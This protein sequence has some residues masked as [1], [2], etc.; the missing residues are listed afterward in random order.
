M[1]MERNCWLMGGCSSICNKVGSVVTCKVVTLN[2][3]RAFFYIKE[4]I[5]IEPKECFPSHT[6]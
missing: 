4:F 6:R 3:E 5:I 1:S 2:L